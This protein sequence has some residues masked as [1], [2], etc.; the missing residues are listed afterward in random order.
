M[1]VSKENWLICTLSTFLWLFRAGNCLHLCTCK[2]IIIR[3]FVQLSGVPTHLAFPHITQLC[4]PMLHKLHQSM[5]CNE[6]AC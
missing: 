5:D 6:S 3:I 2:Y 1:F 4:V